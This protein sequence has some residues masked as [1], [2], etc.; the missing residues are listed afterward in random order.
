MYVYISWLRDLE[1]HTYMCIYRYRLWYVRG[2][3]WRET[4]IEICIYIHIYI[5]ISLV[6]NEI[7]HCT[8]S[9]DVMLLASSP[10]MLT[11]MLYS[12]AILSD[13]YVCC[14]YH[15]GCRNC[16]LLN[17]VMRHFLYGAAHSA[18]LSKRTSYFSKLLSFNMSTAIFLP[19]LFGYFWDWARDLFLPFTAPA[20]WSVTLSL[21]SLGVRTWSLKWGHCHTTHQ[22]VLLTGLHGPP[23]MNVFL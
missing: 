20:I 22:V 7:L 10:L 11:S 14:I 8:V 6:F 19:N 13:K 2:Y 12:P 5:Y 1:S 9:N 3:V 21:H 18:Q 17:F 15:I 4:C 16:E 23:S